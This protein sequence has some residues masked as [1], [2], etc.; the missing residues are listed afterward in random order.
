MKA[1]R[2]QLAMTAV[3]AIALAAAMFAA[4]AEADRGNGRGKA[5]GHWKQRYKHTER[6]VVVPRPS[7]VV[8]VDRHVHSAPSFS[9]LVLAGVI[10]G[11]QISARFGDAPYRGYGYWDPY[12]DMRFSSLRAYRHHSGVHRHPYQLR[13]FAVAPGHSCD[14]QCDHGHDDDYYRGDERSWDRDDDGRYD[15][16]YESWDNWGR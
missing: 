15:G 6:V 12:C 13:V 7:R 9:S 2:I 4:P 16:T 1:P 5:K 11:V 14:R 3:V 8:Y 10:G